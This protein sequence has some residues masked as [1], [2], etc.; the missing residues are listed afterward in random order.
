MFLRKLAKRPRQRLDHH[1][2]PVGHRQSTDLGYP[3]NILD[4]TTPAQRD[5]ADQGSPPP[6]PIFALGPAANDRTGKP[7]IPQ[8][9]SRQTAGEAV[10]RGPT[11][12]SI[13][14]FQ[15]LAEC[16]ARKGSSMMLD[17]LVSDKPPSKVGSPHQK[18]RNP[19]H[20]IGPRL[21]QQTR[22]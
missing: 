7:A 12:D 16:D 22:I 21:R 20:Q 13:A 11:V 4:F 19:D 8:S 9:R 10:H 18:K 17:N 15:K 14:K 1:I 5:G 3:P 2:V 6:P